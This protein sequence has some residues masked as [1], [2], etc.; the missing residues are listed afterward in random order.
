M[1]CDVLSAFYFSYRRD[2]LVVTPQA[3]IR[4]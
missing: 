2:G 1:P 4:I 3:R